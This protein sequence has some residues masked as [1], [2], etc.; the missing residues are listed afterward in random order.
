MGA[1]T[2]QEIQPGI[3][4]FLDPLFL[5]ADPRVRNTQDPPIARAGPFLCVTERNGI[6]CW[7]PITTEPR[8]E[9]VN[10]QARWRS[11]GH[12]QWLSAPQYLNDGANLWEGPNDVFVA[13]SHK[14]LTDTT[15]RAHLSHEGLSAVKEEIQAQIRRQ[16]RRCDYS[17]ALSP[18]L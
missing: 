17:A 6:S 8:R 16:D 13:A 14:E 4:V 11:G 3:V 1:L 18:I 10:L 5:R 7:S 12:P 15:N 9:R 2:E